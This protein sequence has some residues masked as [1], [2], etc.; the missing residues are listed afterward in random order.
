MKPRDVVV[1]GLLI[2][3]SICASAQADVTFFMWNQ[4]DPPPGTM[5]ITG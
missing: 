3:T 1:L 2:L 4:A 5:R